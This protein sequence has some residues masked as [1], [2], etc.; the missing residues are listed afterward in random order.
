MIAVLFMIAA[1]GAIAIAVTIAI[2][3]VQRENGVH[4]EP[5]AMPA[6]ERDRIA[7][8]IL[9]QLLRAGGTSG[10]EALRAI[11]RRAGIAA[12]VTPDIDIANWAEAFARVASRE[13]REN[14]LEFAVQLIATKDRPVP[15]HQYA[16][17]LDLNFGLGFQTD[18]LARLR[19]LYRFDYIDHAKDARPRDAGR[20]AGSL[21]LFV[22]D[23][24]SSA[25]LL[26]IL[27][28]EGSPN[29]QAIVTAYRR[30]AAQHH[31]DRVFGQ[32]DEVQAAAAAR[33][34]E[35]TRAYEA[36]LAMVRE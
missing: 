8:S 20:G 6:T 18:S 26:Q 29:R 13:Q 22:R 2:A 4:A 9:F 24:R 31:P 1:G 10:D 28:I 17:L 5:V 16:A 14:L 19:E 3:F 25:E 32:S 11:R 34:I 23:T 27:G 7:A 33:F 35:I 21:P 15:V 36:L 12:S 30:L